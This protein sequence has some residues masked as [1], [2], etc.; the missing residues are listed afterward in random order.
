MPVLLSDVTNCHLSIITVTVT[1]FPTPDGT[2]EPAT[3][4]TRTVAD[5]AVASL[6]EDG[7]HL[8]TRLGLAPGVVDH[9]VVH[10]HRFEPVAELPVNLEVGVADTVALDDAALDDRFRA[11]DAENPEPRS[12]VSRQ[13]AGVGPV[14]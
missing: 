1:E 5:S 11:L 8:A 12:E 10:L 14:D 9:G 6:S 3:T 4:G 13:I 2:C 7:V